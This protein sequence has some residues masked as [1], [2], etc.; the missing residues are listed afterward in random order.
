MPSCGHAGD[1][2]SERPGT[3]PSDEH[4]RT[5]A[6]QRRL[7]LLSALLLLPPFIGAVDLVGAATHLRF[8]LFPPLV[9]IGYALFADPYG[10]H[11]SLRD[12]VLGPTLGALLGVVTITWLP[13]GPLRVMIVTAAGILV[14]RLL[15]IGLSPVLAVSL[16]TL[17]VGA[18][19][20]TYLFSI[21]ASSL[22]LIVLFRLWRRLLY[23]RIGGLAPP[24]SP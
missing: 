24:S 8:L 5:V 14:M 18:E 22:A 7:S 17:L 1:S 19:G 21:A 20:L 15:R 6:R 12:S 16:L 9:A 4:R 10:K 23:A 11:T 3:G 2:A 13:A